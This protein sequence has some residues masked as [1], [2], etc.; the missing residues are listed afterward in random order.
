VPMLG[1]VVN[2]AG[3]RRAGTSIFTIC[4]TVSCCPLGYIVMEG[5]GRGSNTATIALSM[6]RQAILLYQSGRP[7]CRCKLIKCMP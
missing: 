4:K 7:L 6:L 1:G 3:L 2:L 5:G